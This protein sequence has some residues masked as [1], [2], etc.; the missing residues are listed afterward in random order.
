MT[1]VRAT[2]ALGLALSA[3]LALATWP[4]HG[5]ASAP[6]Q[7]EI[8]QRLDTA[9]PL[10]LPFTDATGRSVR[11]GSYFADRRP[12][13]L[14]LGYYH[15]PNLCGLVIHSLLEALDAGGLPRSD[16]RIVAVS[17][18]PEDT[19]ADALDRERVYVDYA[20]FLR[21]GRTADRPIDLQL[22]VGPAT[23]IATLSERVG[24]AYQRVD[25]SLAAGDDA[26]ASRYAHAAG[27]VLVTPEGHASR[28]LLGVR[29]DPR[30]LRLALVDAAAGTIGSASDR[31]LVLCAHFAPFSGRYDTT[32]MIS[33]RVFAMLLMLGL[34]GWIWRHRCARLGRPMP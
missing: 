15:C 22:L 25:A 20:N 11:L 33:L 29:F 6:P 17:I 23:S 18:D 24:F 10:E 21:A 13:I 30:E 19:P 5:A 16:Y 26:A 9:L 12:V 4:A 14:A 7:T 31:L 3:A 1:S 2:A 28:Y 34:G 8:S 32:V 27:I